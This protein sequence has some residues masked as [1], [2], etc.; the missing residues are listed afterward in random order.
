M[1]EL[2]KYFEFG[3][4]HYDPWGETDFIAHLTN[5]PTGITC[6]QLV[7]DFSIHYPNMKVLPTSVHPVARFLVCICV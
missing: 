6:R 5:Q 1:N 2:C 4:E 3:G 7:N